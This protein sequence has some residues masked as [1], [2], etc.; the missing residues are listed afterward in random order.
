[1]TRSAAFGLSPPTRRASQWSLDAL[2]RL[3]FAWDA[4]PSAAAGDELPRNAAQGGSRHASEHILLSWL[5]G[6][7]CI[8][9][10]SGEQ[11]TV[12][13]EFRLCGVIQCPAP[14]FCASGRAARAWS[15]KAGRPTAEPAA[16]ALRTRQACAQAA[17]GL[18]MVAGIFV[19]SHGM[20]SVA[21]SALS[22]SPRGP[23]SRPRDGRRASDF[24]FRVPFRRAARE[25]PETQ[26]ALSRHVGLAM[27]ADDAE[28]V[29][30]VANIQLCDRMTLPRPKREVLVIQDDVEASSAGA[31]PATDLQKSFEAFRYGFFR[32]VPLL[33][34]AR[35]ARPPVRRGSLTIRTVSL[36]RL[37]KAR[38]LKLSRQRLAEVSASRRE[39]GRRAAPARSHTL[40]P[41]SHLC[42]A[43][44][45]RARPAG[46]TP[47]GCSASVRRS[48][49]SA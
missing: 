40:R 18:M 7:L 10:R 8:E 36:A 5:P 39:S 20:R 26:S 15:L 35:S 47:S 49:T 16:G 23:G 44:A 46:S 27:Q 28:N 3:L 12:R 43:R 6:S 45:D 21:F 25:R 22:C 37:K 41:C 48:S 32:V 30:A 42:D 14:D 33:A 13:R 1:M 4:A 19:S 34:N 38:E 29:S 2:S 17:A 11:C 24:G 9:H 31:G